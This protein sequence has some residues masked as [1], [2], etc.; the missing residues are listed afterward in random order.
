MSTAK[1]WLEEHVMLLETRSSKLFQSLTKK[2]GS[3]GLKIFKTGVFQDNSGGAIES[4]FIWLQFLVLLITQTLTTMN[5]LLLEEIL[6]KLEQMLPK[7][8]MLIHQESIYNKMRMSSILGI[9]LVYSHSQPWDGQ[10]VILMILSLSS[11]V[12]Y[13]KQVM[14]SF[15][16]GLQEW[17]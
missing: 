13:L 10:I 7:N 16:S 6:R 5:T 4:Q 17:S 3:N 15:S 1:I 11:Q 8:S 14:I 9:H 2:H 12:I